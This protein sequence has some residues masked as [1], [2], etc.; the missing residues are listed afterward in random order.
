MT[1]LLYGL[2]MVAVIVGVDV[3]FFRNHFWERLSERRNCHGVRGVL[4]EVPEASNA[5]DHHIQVFGSR[6]RVGRC[7]GLLLGQLYTG[8]SWTVMRWC[9]SLWA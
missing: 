8:I 9:V 2:A 1:Q 3:L 7:L 6:G 4:S 5:S